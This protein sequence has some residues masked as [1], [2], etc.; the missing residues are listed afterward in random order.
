[1]SDVSAKIKMDE[2][3]VKLKSSTLN[4]GNRAIIF[5]LDLNQG[6]YVHVYS[7]RRRGDNSPITRAVDSPG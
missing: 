5:G 2:K 4:K 6:I 3:W 1:M 7:L